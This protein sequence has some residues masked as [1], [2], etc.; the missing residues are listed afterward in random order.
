MTNILF[1]G[2]YATEFKTKGHN[3]DDRENIIVLI[4]VKGHNNKVHKGMSH[5]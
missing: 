4:D 5:I 2:Y 1:Y 3:S